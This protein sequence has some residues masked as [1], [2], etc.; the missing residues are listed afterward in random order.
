MRNELNNKNR[1]FT[2]AEVLIT[3]GVIGIVASLT[4]PII[5][6][7]YK[8]HV[9]EDKL[10]VAISTLQNAAKMSTV[11]N[12]DVSTWDYAKTSSSG[13][14]I[15]FLYYFR[16]YLNVIKT[17]PFLNATD[18]C[19]HAGY[20][21]SDL[22][23]PYLNPNAD[24]YITANGMGIFYHQGVAFARKGVFYVDLSG[25]KGDKLILGK[26]LFSF[27]FVAKG[28]KY[29]ITSTSD[30]SYP[31]NFCKS[32]TKEQHKDFCLNGSPTAYGYASGVFCTALIECNG[33]KIPDD[34]P[35]DF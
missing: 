18:E 6:A 7:A 33:W 17:C 3:L 31:A 24:K 35:I 10:K 28:D 8:K 12:G 30:Y 20:V 32:F 9:I 2:L 4:I 34:Y 26:N 23:T 15:F 19:K 16:P 14:D 21:S 1:A 22:S 11:D 13:N 5:T 25:G 27:N 29:S